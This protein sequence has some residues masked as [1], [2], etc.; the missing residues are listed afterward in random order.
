MPTQATVYLGDTEVTDTNTF[1]N[2]AT[3][4]V[5]AIR[6]FTFGGATVALEIA[7]EGAADG[8]VL[9]PVRRLSG[10]VPS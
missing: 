4:D 10:L 5:T 7:T 3:L 1:V 9:L 2:D 8:A 6:F